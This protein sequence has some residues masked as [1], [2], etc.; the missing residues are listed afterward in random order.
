MDFRKPT[1]RRASQGGSVSR[2]SEK[3]ILL[4]QLLGTQRCSRHSNSGGSRH[5]AEAG[6]RAIADPSAFPVSFAAGND[7][8]GFGRDGRHG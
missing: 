4:A 3:A 8:V 2:D 6:L 7:Y 1:V 5:L